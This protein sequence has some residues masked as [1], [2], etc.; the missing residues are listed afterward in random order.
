MNYSANFS[1]A[2][3]P[4]LLL[5]KGFLLWSEVNLPGNWLLWRQQD[6]AEKSVA[7]WRSK[8][9]TSLDFGCGGVSHS[10]DS[11][12]PPNQPTIIAAWSVSRRRRRRVQF[13][14]TG[15]GGGAEFNVNS[16]A[17][18]HKLSWKDGEK[19]MILLK[20]SSPAIYL[21]R[22][23]KVPSNFALFLK[24]Y[25]HAEE[26]LLKVFFL[27]FPPFNHL[28]FPFMAKKR[29]NITAAAAA[30]TTDARSSFATAT[31]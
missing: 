27:T 20:Y 1:L 25:A 8:K 21:V 12:P 9:K 5:I 30:A 6:R 24:T 14:K 3:P 29:C 11:L 16:A 19:T 22:G 2:I 13:G 7:S 4:S 18:K 26:Q 10:G 28:P 23:K 31:S 15:R 17:Q